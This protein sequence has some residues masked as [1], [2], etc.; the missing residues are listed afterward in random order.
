M[1][2]MREKILREAYKYDGPYVIEDY[3]MTKFV[4]GF[5][6]DYKY[7][8]ENTADLYKAL[9]MLGEDVKLDLLQ[10][11]IEEVSTLLENGPFMFKGVLNEKSFDQIQREQMAELEAEGNYNP[12]TST[13]KNTQMSN[14][15]LALKNKNPWG[16]KKAPLPINRAN[17]IKIDGVESKEA[18]KATLEKA[19]S[20]K[21]PEE[22]ISVLKSAQAPVKAVAPVAGA[23]KAAGAVKGA[24]VA[25]APGILGWISRAFGKV[26]NFFTGGVS[27]VGSAIK[28]G[29]WSSLLQIPLVQGALGV[30]GAVLAF[31]LLKKIFGKKIKPE[32]EA[33]L[34]AAL[35]KGGK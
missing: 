33:Q 1:A 23:A 20:A 14:S 6:E 4:K 32:Q 21:T 31:K 18:L 26:K 9:F 15:D 8:G 29:N 10:E 25:T 17:D 19:A 7:F 2:N 5:S 34:Q 12:G 16:P 13:F 11:N 22:A 3:T 28:S 35:Q 27:S 24:G 30:G